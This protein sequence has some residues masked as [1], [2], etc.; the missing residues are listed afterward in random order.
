[1]AREKRAEKSWKR[2]SK[3]SQDNSESIKS[4]EAVE[5]KAFD[6]RQLLA[7]VISRLK[8]KDL[9]ISSLNNLRD[10]FNLFKFSSFWKQSRMQMQCF[11]VICTVLHPKNLFF[12]YFL[13]KKDENIFFK[14]HSN[15]NA[16]EFNCKNKNK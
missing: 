13:R 8:E 12:E 10:I 5:S 7:F 2:N 16:K 9:M 15:K 11:D 1:M 6:L 3:I 14:N 4:Y